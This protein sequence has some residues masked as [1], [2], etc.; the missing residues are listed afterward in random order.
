MK[1]DYTKPEIKIVSFKTENIATD[2][3]SSGLNI[4]NG[5]QGTF[6]SLSRS[7]A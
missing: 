3:T 7:D 4:T 1:R 2:T 5:I 6:N